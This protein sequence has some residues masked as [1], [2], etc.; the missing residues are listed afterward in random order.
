MGAPADQKANVLLF[1]GGAVGAIAALNIE[2]GG[3]GAVTAVL[4]SNFQVVQD[5]GYTIESVDHGS[6]KGWRPTKGEL[7]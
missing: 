5:A 7:L 2:A 4:R 1:G 6:L 3:L